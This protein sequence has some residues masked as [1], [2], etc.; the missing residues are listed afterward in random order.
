MLKVIMS[1][2]DYEPWGAAMRHFDRIVREGK[3]ENL[4]NLLEELY[5]EGLTDVKLNDMLSYD[6][7]WIFESIGMDTEIQYLKK[8]RAEYGEYFGMGEGRED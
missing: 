3:W 7:D 8:M 6:N 5:P 4:D 2:N 1:F